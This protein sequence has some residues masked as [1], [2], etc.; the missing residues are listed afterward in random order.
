M[1]CIV[2]LLVL[3]ACKHGSSPATT[4]LGEV[5]T[6]LADDSEPPPPYDTAAV[7]RA[8]IAERAGEARDERLVAE[9]EAGDPDKLQAAL[10][11]LAVR[12]RFIRVLESCESKGRLCPPRLDEPAWTHAADY[13]GDPKLDVPLRFDVASW[14]KVTVELQGRACAC[15]TV[16][17][18]DSLDVTIAK[19]ESR[20]TDEVQRDD[21]A[22]AAITR[23]RECLFRLRGRR[24]FR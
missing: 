6:T 19:L 8:L 14:Q 1:K 7:Q 18:I 5:H 16:S 17:C 15:R 13:E 23:A 4:D 20:P 2:L 22:T 10:A 24:A 21:D 12:R 3:A 11:N 9:A